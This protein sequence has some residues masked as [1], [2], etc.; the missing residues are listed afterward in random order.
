M[1]PELP[2]EKHSSSH[3]QKCC[4]PTCFHRSNVDKQYSFSKFPKNIILRKEWIKRINR[5]S[6]NS[7]YRR[8][9][10]TASSKICGL[11]FDLSG[12]KLKSQKLPKFFLPKDF[13]E[14][15]DQRGKK[16]YKFK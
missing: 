11:H 1:D 13:T 8:W 9:T 6:L 14:K 12:R 3:G 10:P 4:V 2:L 7:G 16:Q 15:D 5:Q